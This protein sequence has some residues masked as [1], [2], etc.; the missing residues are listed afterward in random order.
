MAFAAGVITAMVVGYFCMSFLIAYL[1]KQSPGV[2][3][4]Y[5]IIF[6]AAVIVY[7]FMQR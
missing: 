6:G 2:F 5:R 4:V 7:Y 1:K 3:V